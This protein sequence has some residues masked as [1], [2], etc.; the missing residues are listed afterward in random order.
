MRLSPTKK[1]FLALAAVLSIVMAT[2]ASPAGAAT[3]EGTITIKTTPPIV[4]EIPGEPTEHPC[5]GQTGYVFDAEAYGSATSGDLVV[6]FSG[7]SL[8]PKPGTS[9]VVYDQLDFYP[10][11]QNITYTRIAA[12]DQYSLDGS[13]T[14]AIEVNNLDEECGKVNKC[15]FGL[16]LIVS[17][18]LD[19]DGA[20]LPP[21]KKPGAVAVVNAT[22][23]AAGGL[24]LTYLAGD[25][26]EY[27]VLDGIHVNISLTITF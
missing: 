9:P 27:L 16:N 5:D 13:L 17:G 4:I 23:N 21:I 14:M 26:E 24:P 6:D 25:C 2:M 15:T 20:A 1:V 18:S 11:A 12:P 7:K 22:T 8:F 19:N 3:L 10:L